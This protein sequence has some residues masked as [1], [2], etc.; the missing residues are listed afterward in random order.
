MVPNLAGK[1]INKIF[2]KNC[3]NQKHAKNEGNISC[4]KVHWQ[5]QHGEGFRCAI[6]Q[7]NF[8]T[9]V[10]RTN[11]MLKIHG[12]GGAPSSR[13]TKPAAAATADKEEK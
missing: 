7:K 10:A 11:H 9:A 5:S 6:C 8:C 13:P 12:D 1:L 3:N 4:R 2:L